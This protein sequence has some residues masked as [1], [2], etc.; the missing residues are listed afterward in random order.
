MNKKNSKMSMFLVIILASSFIGIVTAKPFTNIPAEKVQKW[1]NSNNQNLIVI[2]LRPASLFKSGHIPGAINVPVL[3]SFDWSILQDWI[4]NQG[5]NQL[6]HKIVIHCLGGIASPTGA[7]MLETAGFKKVYN[8]EGGFNAWISAG[9]P[10]EIAVTHS[11]ADISSTPATK[12]IQIGGTPPKFTL[13][14]GVTVTI[15]ELTLAVHSTPEE[16]LTGSGYSEICGFTKFKED[17]SSIVTHFAKGVWKFPGGTFEGKY[18]Y[19]VTKPLGSPLGWTM[20]LISMT[21]HGTGVF[22]G[23]TLKLTYE[24]PQIGAHFTGFLYKPAS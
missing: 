9:Y 19:V 12:V 22:E 5:Q 17:G 2:D 15:G 3:F 23:Q 6:N 7:Q 18:I 16:T 1:V 4:N 20:K 13:W 10:I 8:M 24:G 11:G 14:K 21:L